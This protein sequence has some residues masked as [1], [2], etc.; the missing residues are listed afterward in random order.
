[1]NFPRFTLNTTSMIQA[2]INSQTYFFTISHITRETE[3]RLLYGLRLNNISYFI[4][5]TYGV[6]DGEQLDTNQPL[7]G[8]IL[9]ELNTVITQV[10]LNHKKRPS[11][12]QINREIFS[13]L[14]RLRNFGSKTFKPVLS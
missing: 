10:E 14:I 12:E 1:M 5:K 7:A 3:N 13:I 9:K 11:L 6:N 4:S 2:K 8:N